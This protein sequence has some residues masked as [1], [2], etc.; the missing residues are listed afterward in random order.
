MSYV[1]G[2]TWEEACNDELQLLETIF[3]DGRMVKEQSLEDIRTILHREE[4]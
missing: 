4:F 1:D 3:K 2:L